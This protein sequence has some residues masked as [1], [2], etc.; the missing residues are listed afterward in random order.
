MTYLSDGVDE[1]PHQLSGLS[2]PLP[3]FYELPL[4]TSLC[5]KYLFE[6]QY[7][8]KEIEKKVITLEDLRT[9]LSKVTLFLIFY[10]AQQTKA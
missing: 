6:S 2:T 7:I 9:N 10:M 8:S 5:P 3:S 1:D 4:A